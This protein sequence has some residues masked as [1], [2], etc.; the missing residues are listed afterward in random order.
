MPP[1]VLLTD[2]INTDA[3]ALLARGAELRVLPGGLS[4]AGGHEWLRQQ[5]GQAD[6]LIV[7]RQL[8]PDLFDAAPSLKVVA[9][10]GVGLDFI[11]VQAATERGI[12]VLNTPN[13][14]ANAVAEYAIA[15][16]LA[17]ARRLHEYDRAVREARWSVRAEAGRSTYELR[18]RTLGL[19]GFGA[20]GRQVAQIAAAGFGMRV[21]AHTRSPQRLPAE[22]PGMDLPALFAQSDTIVLACPLTPETRGL[23]GDTLL[24]QVRPGA[25]LVNVARGPVVDEPAL[26]RALQSGRL[27]MAVLDVLGE[28]PLAPGHPLADC[29]GVLFT[30][31]LAGMTAEAEHA[32]GMKAVTSVLAVLAGEPVDNIVNPEVLVS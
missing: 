21:I 32:M 13:V 1:I 17:A 20:I 26:V 11:P 8:P 4:A 19:V 10:H 23:V 25:C 3:Q 2:P 15:A 14:N 29:P 27:G 18:G 31:H 7:R 5:I 9:R 24:E 16:M 30:P 6:G 12:P 28:Q 22:V